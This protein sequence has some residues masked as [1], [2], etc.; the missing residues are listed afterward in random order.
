MLFKLYLMW[1]SNLQINKPEKDINCWDKKKK[2]LLTVGKYLKS[3][4]LIM[5]LEVVSGEKYKNNSI[6]LLLISSF[7]L[8]AET[9]LPAEYT[10]LQLQSIIRNSK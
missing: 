1:T 3:V 5:S 4:L 10:F 2:K 7:H 8:S 9:A 6:Y